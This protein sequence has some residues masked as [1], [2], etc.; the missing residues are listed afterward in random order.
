MAKSSEAV[1]GAVFG[2]LKVLRLY[3]QEVGTQGKK[4]LMA[5]CECSCSAK[6]VKQVAFQDLGDKV[7]SCGCSKV[8]RCFRH[9][10][11]GTFE[12][13]VWKGVKQ[14]CFN[15]NNKS[16]PFYKDKAPPDSWQT[17]EGFLADMGKAPDD[18]FTLERVR[19]S[20]P[21]SKENCVWASRLDQVLN[22]SNTR[23][24]TDGVRTVC[25]TH[26]AESLGISLSTVNYHL[27]MGKTLQEILGSTWSYTV[28]PSETADNKQ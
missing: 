13:S 23:W 9:G 25:L 15:P 11:F 3:R 19:N 5:E 1:L 7:I 24:V 21:Y 16:Y 8:D 10:G 22:R 17:F 14:R 26:A 27:R 2:K 28:N 6:T 12:Y 20:L 18:T 4:K